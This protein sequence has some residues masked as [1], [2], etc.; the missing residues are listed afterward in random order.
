MMT[1]LFAVLFLAVP[2]QDYPSKST[3]DQKGKN[4][5]SQEKKDPTA[6]EEK[7]APDQEKKPSSNQEE[8]PSPDQESP[9][10]E[11]EDQ[12]EPPVTISKPAW[13]IG[14][15]FDLWVTDLDFTAQT[16]T[17]RTEVETALHSGADL[18]AFVGL[19]GNWGAEV[20]VETTLG[21]DSE[22]ESLVFAL[23]LQWELP[24]LE[25]SPLVPA[26][27]AGVLYGS[28]TM[29]DIPG[30][31]DDA[32]GFEGGLQVSLPLAGER[33]GLGLTLAVMGRNLEFDFEPDSAATVY[34]DSIGGMGVRFV[35]GLEVRF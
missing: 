7:P 19:G 31:F 26:L 25:D 1:E 28:Y 9:P 17:T 34:D 16:A 3:Q 27:R 23:S 5:T 33:G 32:V 29:D 10:K 20:G 15:R 14:A 18:F 30:D 8:K 13:S 24:I 11:E 2:L 22:T 35:A 6:Q 4:P 12:T 21:G